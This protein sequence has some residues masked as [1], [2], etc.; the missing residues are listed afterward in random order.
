M[1]HAP[2]G[3]CHIES[4]WLDQGSAVADSLRISQPQSSQKATD[5]DRDA[6]INQYNGWHDVKYIS[7]DLSDIPAA[8]STSHVCEAEPHPKLRCDRTEN[9]QKRE[10]HCSLA[11]ELKRLTTKNRVSLGSSHTIA[12]GSG[13]QQE[14]PRELEFA[15]LKRKFILPFACQRFPAPGVQSVVLATWHSKELQGR[16]SLVVPEEFS[17]EALEPIVTTAEEI[18]E[19]A[20]SFA[21]QVPLEFF[22]A[23]LVDYKV[24]SA[25]RAQLAAEKIVR[26][27]GLF[28]H[29][30][31]WE[32]MGHLHRPECQL[33]E[34]AR[35][36]LQFA[37]HQLW[38]AMAA[39]YHEA[40]QGVSFV[41][42]V[43]ALTI[44]Q[45]TEHI[46]TSRYTKLLSK[47]TTHSEFIDRLNACFMRL[48]DPDCMY[49]HF[50]ALDD[51]KDGVKLWRKLDVFLS[52]HRSSSMS[53]M[54]SRMRR[55][56]PIPNA[57]LMSHGTDKPEDLGDSCSIRK[58]GRVRNARGDKHFE[59]VTVKSVRGP[60][61][62]SGN[63][64]I[65]TNSPYDGLRIH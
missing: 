31:Y 50:A 43:L 53:R 19:N 7:V 23:T 34:V 12:C 44:K 41:L 15:S 32:L 45:G 42:P 64:V 27:T 58:A 38:S 13:S 14:S 49:A 52:K 35:E 63:Q 48:L 40:P 61:Q 24:F 54:M 62:Q 56:S 8:A 39:A 46:F 57:L 17:T 4:V 9:V 3:N 51:T 60:L 65:G 55:T 22:T 59:E 11:L 28:A 26:L 25:L 21:K 18:A 1:G 5:E 6:A 47:T 20:T 30:T 36:S 37:I 10:D 33:P 29:Y 2:L 16:L